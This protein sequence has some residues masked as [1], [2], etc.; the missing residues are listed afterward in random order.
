MKKKDIK[1][2]S[3]KLIDIIDTTNEPNV[4]QNMS[5]TKRKA[6]DLPTEVVK[7]YQLKAIEQDKS[8]KKI[9]EEVLIKAAKA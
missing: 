3:N 4:L 5:N 9:L 1:S 8:V 7:H 2:I 6:L